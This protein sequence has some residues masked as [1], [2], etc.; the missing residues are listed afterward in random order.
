MSI[1]QMATELYD[2]LLDHNESFDPPLRSQFE[3]YLVDILHRPLADADILIT[4]MLE[5]HKGR[6]TYLMHETLTAIRAIY[7][8][9][10][11]I[12]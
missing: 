10:G 8:E 1:E 2:L 9:H 4:E 7:E 5:R 6:D 11:R 12:V 3:Q